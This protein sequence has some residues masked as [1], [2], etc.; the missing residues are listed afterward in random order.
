M[1]KDGIIKPGCH[2]MQV[3]D[4]VDVLAT[5]G[6]PAG[7]SGQFKDDLTGQPLRDDLVKEARA[8]ALKYFHDKGFGRSGDWK[9][10]DRGPTVR[11]SR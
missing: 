10:A 7:C 1:L 8:K 6:L 3:K 5:E 2:G 4:E 11:R 9:S